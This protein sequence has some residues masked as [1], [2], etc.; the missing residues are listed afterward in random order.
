MGHVFL[1][2]FMGA[3]KTTVGRLVAERLALPFVDLDALVE[4][5]EGR[6]IPAIFAEAGEEVFRCAET[7]ALDA[8]AESAD[9]VV[10]CGGGIVLADENRVTLKRLGTVVHLAVSAEEALAR[11]GDAQGRPLL[12]GEAGRM[13]TTLLDARRAL[14]ASIADVVV[15]T[16]GR[17]PEEVAEEV[18]RA[19]REMREDGPRLV[20]VEMTS[21]PYDVV[22]GPGSLDGIGGRARGAVSNASNVALVTDS[23][24]DGLYGGR[25]TASLSSAGFVV[26]PVVVPAGEAS[27][28][29][30]R[31][32]EVLGALSSAGLDRTD[33]VVALGGGVVGDLGGFCAAVYLRGIA[34]VQAPTTLLAQVDSA[35]G[36]KTGVDLPAG[37]NLVGAFWQPALVVADTAI[38]ASLADAEW[39][40]GL[41]EVA[42]TAILSGGGDLAWMEEHAAALVARERAAVTAAVEMCVRYK[43]GVAAADERE[44]GRRECLNLGHTL[45]H[46]IEKVGGYGAVPHGVAVAAGIRFAAGLAEDL[47][48]SDAAWTRRQEALLDALDLPETAS[49]FDAAA[50]RETMAADK[51]ARG[52]RVRFALATAP[53]VCDVREIDNDVLAAR[54]TAWA[55]SRAAAEG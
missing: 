24:V 11:I 29:W 1:T 54:L 45:G 27:K 21:R 32:G 18:V 13:A 37:K 44:G 28:S 39:R 35:I 7:G 49:R 51:K 34:F 20:R 23:T 25:V 3:G 46:A 4:E 16:G 8:V 36:G 12:M 55:G 31:A 38:L 53:G 48:A 43:G 40:S 14:Y 42:K 33:A 10:A 6:D 22:I 19:L 50:L 52:G 15:D 2:G 17:S 41:A 26:H 9:S 30:E 47:G 5:R